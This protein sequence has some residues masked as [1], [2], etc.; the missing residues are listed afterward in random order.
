MSVRRDVAVEACV[1][2]IDID[3]DRH[4]L[5]DKQFHGV[6]NRCFGEGRDLRQEL[7]MDLFGRRVGMVV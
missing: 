6:V 7:Q 1:T 5:A 3:H 2:P 4:T